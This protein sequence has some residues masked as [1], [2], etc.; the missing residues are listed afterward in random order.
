MLLGL[1]ALVPVAMVYF[2]RRG[3]RRDPP[4]VAPPVLP[5]GPLPRADPGPA[6]SP[7]LRPGRPRA[8]ARW[9]RPPRACARPPWARCGW[10]SCRPGPG[11]DRRARHRAGGHGAG[12]PAARTGRCRCP[13][14]WPCCWCRRRCSCR[15]A[16]PVPS[17]TPA[18]RARPRPSASSTSSTCRWP[19]G[20][21]IGGGPLGP[22]QRRPAR[23]RDPITGG[24]VEAGLD[25]ASPP[26]RLSAVRVAYPGRT[27]P[28]LDRLDLVLEPGEHVAL[29]GPRVPASPRCSPLLLGFLHPDEGTVRVGDVDLA[30]VDP[31]AWRQQVTWVP[32]RPHLF[33]GTL[34]DNLRVGDADATR[35]TAPAGA[36]RRRAGRDGRA[37]CRVGWRPVSATAGSP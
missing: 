28:A 16:G 34:A 5:L 25:P 32:Q 6:H 35:R 17:S 7:G 12:A 19:A 29:V 3:A 18:P 37:S 8:D 24:H 9:L 1:V 23:L 2:G 30:A 10:P 21:E 31:A 15:C 33:A 26:I 11:A 36:G 13:P 20:L 14:P 22:R 4:P 27:V